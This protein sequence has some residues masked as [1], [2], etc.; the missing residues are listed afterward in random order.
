MCHLGEANAEAVQASWGRLGQPSIPRKLTLTAWG[1][2][3]T[4]LMLVE[5]NE[6][7]DGFHN[8]SL[9]G[10]EQCAGTLATCNTRD[11]GP[12]V[13]AHTPTAQGSRV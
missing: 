1:T 12:S 4:A 6:P 13:L 2:L 9:G 8:V 3:A 5:L 7:S 11:L 10:K